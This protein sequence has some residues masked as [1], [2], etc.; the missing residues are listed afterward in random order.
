M[1]C[2]LSSLLLLV[3]TS[4]VPATGQRGDAEFR[5]V[6]PKFRTRFGGKLEIQI[7]V[8]RSHVIRL[9]NGQSE[10]GAQLPRPLTPSVYAALLPSIWMLLN[11]VASSDSKGGASSLVL[12]ATIDHALRT[13]SCSAVKGL[14]V[15]FVTRLLLVSSFA[16]GSEALVL[17]NHYVA[18][19]EWRLYREFR[20]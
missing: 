4:S 1:Y 10:T 18:G 19:Q 7:D 5:S 20:T 16:T 6:D 3:T 17:F 2:E 13:P 15:E 9:L 14:T 8:V 11:H 12:L